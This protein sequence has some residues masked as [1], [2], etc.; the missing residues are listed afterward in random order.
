M[1]CSKT[2]VTS[3]QESWT[4][5]GHCLNLNNLLTDSDQTSL[6]TRKSIPKSRPWS[7]QWPRARHIIIPKSIFPQ[8][9][10]ETTLRSRTKT[11]YWNRM[12]DNLIRMS[13]SEPTTTLKKG[14][15][16]PTNTHIPS[17]LN[18]H[19]TEPVENAKSVTQS[20]K[21]RKTKSDQK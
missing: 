10:R 15:I 14:K 18:P 11:R 2:M 6:K 8:F 4:R 12:E 21:S 20:W 17:I 19:T 13:T 1:T 5:S 16:E 7:D 3:C 9:E